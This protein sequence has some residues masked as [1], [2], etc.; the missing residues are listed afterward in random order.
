MVFA[1]FEVFKGPMVFKAMVK[2]RRSV[3]LTDHH[4]TGS[5]SNQLLI[6]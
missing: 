1:L 3:H 4:G 2:L 6:L 5:D